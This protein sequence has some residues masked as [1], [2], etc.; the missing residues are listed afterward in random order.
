[1]DDFARET[2][3]LAKESMN[4]ASGGDTLKEVLHYGDQ[5]KYHLLR[6][7]FLELVEIREHLKKAK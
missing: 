1:M 2:L 6:G 3:K 4:D 7:I 5:A